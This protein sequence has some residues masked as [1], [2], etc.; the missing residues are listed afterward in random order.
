MC[1]GK[2]W[3]FLLP[4]VLWS[5][6]FSYGEISCRNEAGKPVD[7]FIIYKLP[8]YKIGSVGSGLE[9]MYLDPTVKEWQLSKFLVNTSQSAVGRTL[10]QLYQEHRHKS[11]NSAYMLYNDAP[12]SLDYIVH[13]GHTKGVLHFDQTQGFW[14][15]H[16]VPHFPPFPERGY[17]WPSSGKL[18]GQTALCIT[19]KSTQFPQIAEQLLYYNP[20][21]Y[22]CSLPEV[23]RHELPR[24]SCICEGSVKPWVQGRRMG[25][26]LSAQGETFLSLAKSRFFVDDIYTGWAAQVLKTTL[27]TETWQRKEHELPSNC[28]LPEHVLNIKRIKLPGPVEFCS[29]FDHAKWCVSQEDGDQ[30]I[31]TGD[32]NREDCQ[33]WKSGGL[34]CSQNPVIYHAFRGAVSWFVRC[35]DMFKL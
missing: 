33:Q 34:I 35:R 2:M 17:S 30:W 8:K 29:H 1:S 31:C 21:V 15:S 4:A 5:F 18:N 28:S 11:N 16:S 22:N 32:L 13:Y 24:M 20:R 27:L 23:F 10:E 7:W 14:L 12:P 19:Y 3:L 25:K 9:Y 6:P 26:L